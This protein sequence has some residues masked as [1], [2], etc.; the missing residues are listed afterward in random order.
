MLYPGQKYNWRKPVNNYSFSK[1][2]NKLSFQLNP[3]FRISSIQEK[4]ALQQYQ[5]YNSWTCILILINCIILDI[6]LW[7]Y[8]FPIIFYC[9]IFLSVCLENIFLFQF[10]CVIYSFNYIYTLSFFVVNTNKLPIW[11][12]QSSKQDKIYTHSSH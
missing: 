9:I 10:K 7:S 5:F 12:H 11:Y 6:A 2:K 8:S 4:D 1:R 3:F